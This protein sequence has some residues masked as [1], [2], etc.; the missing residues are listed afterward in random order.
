MNVKFT[1]RK[2]KVIIF[3]TREKTNE[4]KEKIVPAFKL[5]RP[6]M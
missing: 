4:N 1:F 2:N 3:E 5:V 6:V